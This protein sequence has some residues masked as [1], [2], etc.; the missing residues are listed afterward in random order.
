MISIFFS[1]AVAVNSGSLFIVFSVLTR[2]EPVF[3]ML[4]HRNKLDLR[5]VPD[6]LNTGTRVP[7]STERTP[8]ER[9]W[10]LDIWFNLETLLSFGGCFYLINRCYSYRW[11]AIVFWLNYLTLVID[12]W[13]FPTFGEARCC[14]HSL[15]FTSTKLHPMVSIAIHVCGSCNTLLP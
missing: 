15:Y 3:T 13:G 14:S 1:A 5:C 9:Q 10:G 7:I 11:V 6:F 2:V 4:L 12:L 8:S